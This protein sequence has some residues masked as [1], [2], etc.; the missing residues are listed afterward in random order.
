M[1][2]D[3]VLPPWIALFYTKVLLGITFAAPPG[4]VTAEAIQRGLSGG[5]MP[6]FKVKLGAAIGDLIFITITSF[7]LAYI[8]RYSSIAKYLSIAGSSLLFYMGYRNLKK[9]LYYKNNFNSDTIVDERRLSGLI[10]GFVIA[11]SSPFA[12]GFWVGEFSSNPPDISNVAL[13]LINNTYILFGIILWD[14]IFC[15]F[16]ALG[17]KM[18]SDKSMRIISGLAGVFLCV[19]GARFFLMAIS[20]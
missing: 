1:L 12:L 6:A 11:I 14:I 17:K 5:F 9:A 7:F 20:I 19:Y 4:P 16:L 8:A 13:S 15:L 18:V 2:V 10:V 3:V